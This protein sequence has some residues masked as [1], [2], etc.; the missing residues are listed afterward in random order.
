MRPAPA[1]PAPARQHSRRA[2]PAHRSVRSAASQGLR[3]HR[4]GPRHSAPGLPGHRNS[5]FGRCAQCA[6]GVL[7]LSG[8]L[9]PPLPSFF[10]FPSADARAGPVRGGPIPVMPKPEP[11][12]RPG[13]HLGPCTRLGPQAR[14]ALAAVATGAFCVQW[15]SFALNPALP[16]VRDALHGS[17]AATPWVVSGY[18]LAAGSLMPLMRPPRRPL[19]AAPDADPRTVA[20][21]C[22]LRAVRAGTVAAAAGGGAGGAGRRMAR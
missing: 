4:P 10:P 9:H 20:L 22:H 21:R 19:R 13:T 1:S 2:F 17:A 16:E 7:P 12:T 14:W 3:L 6:P 8:A 11:H 15:D 18:L 5:P